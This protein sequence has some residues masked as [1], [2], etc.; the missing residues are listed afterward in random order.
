VIS[1]EPR[2]LHQPEKLRNVSKN[3]FVFTLFKFIVNENNASL[4]SA[5]SIECS[6]FTGP[7][8]ILVQPA[9]EFPQIGGCLRVSS[10]LIVLETSFLLRT[11]VHLSVWKF[12]HNPV[13][14]RLSKNSAD[15]EVLREVTYQDA[16]FL[17]DSP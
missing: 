12:R 6:P 15:P 9:Q 1:L 13:T 17:L 4:S 7:C 2:T 14:M 10:R 11:H 8:R 5:E 16:R 3:E